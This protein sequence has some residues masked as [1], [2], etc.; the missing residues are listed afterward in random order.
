MRKTIK[1]ALAAAAI[2]VFASP[3]LSEEMS[4]SP[5]N[6]GRNVQQTPALLSPAQNSQP[7]AARGAVQRSRATEEQFFQRATGNLW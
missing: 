7:R 3:A 2:I 1:S 5:A 4:E 6:N